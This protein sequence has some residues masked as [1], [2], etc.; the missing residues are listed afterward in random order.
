MKRAHSNSNELPM[1]PMRARKQDG[2]REDVK[3]YDKR[4]LIPSI[5]IAPLLF[6]LFY[7]LAM[8]H[9]PPEGF[10]FEREPVL[11]GIYKCCEAGGRSSQSW[12]DRESI[13]CRG[14][15][16]YN[17]FG[18]N[19]NDCGFKS[20]LSGLQVEVR[21]AYIPSAHESTPIVVQITSQGHTYYN[22][23]DERIRD[24][25]LSETNGDAQVLALWGALIFHFMLFVYLNY[26]HK[27]NS[28]KGD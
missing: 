23:D 27:S 3:W 15:G 21:R 22:V 20:E 11:S 8:R 28:R 2:N 16:Y 5:V 24:R 19:L 14:Y 13:R 4:L 7:A 10:V 18:R 17:Y 6:V 9:K 25:W 1:P 12:I 26:F